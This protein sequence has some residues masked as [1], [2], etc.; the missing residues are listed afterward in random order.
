MTKMYHYRGF[1]E[2]CQCD[3][4]S[5][6]VY[7]H[8]T[9]KDAEFAFPASLVSSDIPI[10]KGEAP[11]LQ[12][13]CRVSPSPQFTY[14]SMFPKSFCNREAGTELPPPPPEEAEEVGN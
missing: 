5:H 6:H 7:I 11:L 3:I 13:D 12:R 1:I 9:S 10:Q 2:E 14:Q 4:S 8:G